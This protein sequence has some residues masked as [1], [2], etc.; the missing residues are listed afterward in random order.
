M[1]LT[2]YIRDA[3]IQQVMNDVPRE[4][5]EEM[6]DKLILDDAVDQLPTAVKAVWK[7][8]NLQ[9]YIKTQSV[10]PVP[11]AG[12]V[13]VPCLNRS[14]FKLRSVAQQKA[15]ELVKLRDAQV[16]RF[17]SLRDQ[18]KSIAYGCT[19]RK[20]LAE[21]LPELEKYIPKEEE[22]SRN[23]PMVANVV[24]DFVKAGWPKGVKK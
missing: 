19:T 9:G 8:P 20:A 18:L 16:A 11:K 7:D 21:T 17:N 4:R 12:V 23:L 5:Y 10:Y 14:D 3:Y 2:N 13:Q 22:T 6:I 1:K 24:S 15:E